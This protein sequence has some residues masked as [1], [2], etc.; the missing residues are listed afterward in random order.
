MKLPQ[1]L[2]QTPAWDSLSADDKAYKAKVLEAHAAMIE[3][4][5]YNIGRVIQHLKGTGQYDN[6]LIMF[7]SDNGKY[8]KDVGVILPDPAAFPASLYGSL[9]D[10]YS[11]K[12]ATESTTNI[13]QQDLQTLVD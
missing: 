7:T 1:R 10:I 5:D 6:T 11:Q 13:T 2:P 12:N 8:A 3:N 9:V 4:M